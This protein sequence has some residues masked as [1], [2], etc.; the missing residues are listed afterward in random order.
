M[1]TKVEQ[2]TDNLHVIESHGNPLPC[3]ND[4]YQSRPA[5]LPDQQAKAIAAARNVHFRSFCLKFTTRA[6][7]EMNKTCCRAFGISMPMNLLVA[8]EQ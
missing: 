4:M 5:P 6:I 2:A 7:I 1:V 8:T 3:R